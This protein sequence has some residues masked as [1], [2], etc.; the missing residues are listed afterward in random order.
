MLLFLTLRAVAQVSTATV[1]GTVQDSSSAAIP[2]AQLKL[3]NNQTGTEN[4]SKTG[5]D[6]RFVLTGILPGTYRLWIQR[7]GFATTQFS[8]ITLNIGDTRNFLVRLKIGPVTESVTVDASGITPNTN[9]ASMTTVVDRRFVNTVPLNGQ[10]F[11]DLISMTPGIVTLN[12]QAAGQGSGE[13]GDFS[14]NGQ[15]PGANSFYIDGISAN[16]SLGPSRTGSVIS[17]TGSSAGSTA[18]GTTQSLVSVDALQELRVLTATYSAEYGRTPGGQFTFLTRSGTERYHGSIYTTWR[19]NKFDAPDWFAKHIVGP[20]LYQSFIQNDSGGTFSSPFRLPRTSYGLDKTFFFLS[21]ERLNLTQQQPTAVYFVPSYAVRQEAV[22]TAH[23]FN[24]FY[25][26]TD[27]EEL[28]TPNGLPSG[29][30]TTTYAYDAPLPA[31]LSASNLR[32]DHTFTPKLSAFARYGDT[33]SNSRQDSVLSVVATDRIRTQTLTLGMNYLAS[34]KINNELRF[35]FAQSR[36]GTEAVP[37][38]FFFRLN[39]PT[40][41]QSLGL[42]SA[43]PQASGTVAVD[44]VGIG[45]SGVSS[46]CDSRSIEQWNTRDTF[47]VQAGKHLFKFGFDQRHLTS[48]IAPPSLSVRAY[49]FT[50]QSMIDGIASNVTISRNEPAHPVLNQFST[51]VQDEWKPTHSLTVSLGIRSEAN[52]APHGADGQD[53]YT[54]IGE[55]THPSTLSVASRG[56]PLWKGSWFNLAPR[57]GVAWLVDSRPERELVLRIGSGVFFDTGN[58]QALQAFTEAGF[59]TTTTLQNVPLPLTPDQL[60][61]N[62]GSKTSFARSTAFAFPRHLQLPYSLQWDVALEKALGRN[63]TLTLSY[64]GSHGARLLE[65]QRRYIAPINSQFGNISFFPNGITSNYQSLQTK[66]QRSIAHGVQALVSYTW[67][68]AL[69]Y[70]STDPTFPLIYGNSDYD[71][72]HNV[73]GA[74]SWDLPRP[75]RTIHRY[76]IGSWSLEGRLIARTGFPITLLGN[77]LLDPVTDDRYYSGVNLVPHRP[78]YIDDPR[79]PGGRILN[80]GQN[81]TSPAFVLPNGNSAGDAPRNIVRGFDAIQTNIG[82]RREMPMNDKI[83]FQLKGEVFNLLNHPNYGYI[84]PAVTDLLFG[85]STRMLN[86]SFGGSGALYQQGG[87]RSIQLGFRLVF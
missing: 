47:S 66:V 55:V 24:Y 75:K 18:L 4:D 61:A 41:N 22:S 6:G 42:S 71:V 7:T 25:G 68:H 1:V 15:N 76:V 14:V 69:D 87:P 26:P 52:F 48:R 32:I 67:A 86:Q 70:G 37:Q 39:E 84:D 35:G 27:F 2:D 23:Y 53:A 62:T 79:Y 77:R 8:G 9:D 33:P 16:L 57:L 13:P 36:M 12:P 64:I 10:S 28:S 82:I 40:F 72:R 29:L 54:A 19:E 30:A 46:D 38:S 31:H 85:Q 45:S 58:R 63:Q 80:G 81:A 49:L 20:S 50:R 43:C 3:I 78:F 34:S 21:F 11:Q 65:Q 60:D 44:V 51:F 5:G 73:E 56:T 83:T 74:I 17:S 59:H